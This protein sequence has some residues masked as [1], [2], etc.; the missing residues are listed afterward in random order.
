[1]IR[2]EEVLG[3]YQVGFYGGQ[4]ALYPAEYMK[5]KK[6][7]IPHFYYLYLWLFAIAGCITALI[8]VG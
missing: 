5:Q 8:W 3:C 1:M 7:R 2:T 6:S 4:K